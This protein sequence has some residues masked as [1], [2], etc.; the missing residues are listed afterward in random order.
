MALQTAETSIWKR[1]HYL[2]RMTL[3]DLVIAYFQH[4]TIIVYL[5]L[6]VAALIV[7]ALHP[8]TLSQSIIC[9]VFA[10]AAWHTAWFF[11][12]RDIM[13]GH[14]MFKIPAL[15]STWKR[16]HYD[17]HVDPNH[18]EV[19]FGALG[20]TLPTVA[21]ASIPTGYLIGGTGGAA[22]TF[23]ATL[24]ITC[25]NEFIHCIM[26]LSFKPK[27]KLIARLKARHLL[28]HF[29]HESGNFGIANNIWDAW[30]GYLY[31]KPGERKKSPTVFNLGY[32]DEVAKIYP[33]VQELSGGITSVEAQRRR[34]TG[35]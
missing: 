19:L 24:L 11:I 12:H 35:K 9:L 5:A 28:H 23:A 13:H 1:S 33:C 18:L 15:A 8:A 31:E 27:N 29:H 34:N 25:Y 26:H 22:L 2:D 32:T 21:I 14:W 30:L 6:T 3:R 4:Y 7:F 20:H 16:I 17:H 10:W